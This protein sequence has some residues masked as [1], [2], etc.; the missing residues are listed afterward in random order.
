MIATLSSSVELLE[1]AL[2]Y[3]S[4][5]LATVDDTLLDR[6]TPCAGW[7]LSDLLA[8]MEDS[9]D[10]FADAAGGQVDVHVTRV[11]RSSAGRISVIREKACALLGAWAGPRPGDVLVGGLD[12]TSTLLVATA[13]LEITAHGWDVG[14]ATG[15]A[16]P[17]PAALARELLPVARLTVSATD[18]GLRFGPERAVGP[19]A[20]Y[21]EQLLAL[22]GRTTDPD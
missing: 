14:Q 22:L 10:A 19:S 2:G 8:H 13:A 18:R 4:G 9:L 11:E 15:S 20:A 16:A 3:T 5:Q 1:R 12:L 7:L 21:D 17:V 6:P